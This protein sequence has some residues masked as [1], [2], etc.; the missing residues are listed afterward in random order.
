MALASWLV[1]TAVLLAQVFTAI[2]YILSR[3]IMKDITFIFALSTYRNAVFALSITSLA[4]YFEK[5][6]EKKFGCAIWFLLFASAATVTK[7]LGLRTKQR[8]IKTFGVLLSLVGALV[9][10]LYK[11]KELY[12]VYHNQ[13]RDSQ[14][15][16]NQNSHTHWTC[17]T[18]LI[19]ASCLSRALW[20][21]VQGRG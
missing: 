2:L 9:A 12:I 15:A 7:K 14:T 19:I 16:T 21:I 20:F 10:S 18:I 5:S 13:H 6:G 17:G 8:K 4:Y 11:G 1:L 3:V